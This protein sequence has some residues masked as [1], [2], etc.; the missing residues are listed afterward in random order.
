MSQDSLYMSI[1]VMLL[2]LILTPE[3][4]RML[5]LGSYTA[6]FILFLALPF[7]VP[8][9][10]YRGLA[11]GL[12]DIPKIVTSIQS[13][14]IIRLFG[15]LLLWHM[16]F[17]L[18]GIMVAISFS[19]FAGFIF[20]TDKKDWR[21]MRQRQRSKPKR[22]NQLMVTSLP[23]IT[24]QLFLITSMD[25]DI[26]LAKAHMSAEIAGLVAGLLLVQR[27]FFF[28]FSSFSGVLQPIIARHTDQ[29]S[30]LK[31]LLL[32]IIGIATATTLGM[33]LFVPL[34]DQ[35]T[36]FLLGADY[37][38]IAPLIPI[39]GLIGAIMMIS[40]LCAI[41]LIMRGEKFVT[42]LMFSFGVAQI[43][44][45]AALAPEISSIGLERFFIVKLVIQSLCTLFMIG[46]AVYIG[47]H[48]RPELS[49][50]DPHY[51]SHAP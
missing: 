32:M 2:I 4:G 18:A 14:W 30:A 42:L 47:Y 7:F 1:P 10:I 27:I 6:L 49:I 20:S 29:R 11:Q 28:A 8:M 36:T 25:S 50:S 19:I 46:W 21:L 41:F 51:E 24:L 12:I 35:V 3:I 38:A 13:E 5:N 34:S 16:G 37:L 22:L 9:V 45:L 40:Y 26:I 15:S 39:A 23:Y 17:G 31:E 33:A 44:Y 48:P 43:L